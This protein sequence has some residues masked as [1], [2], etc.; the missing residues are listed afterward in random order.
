MIDEE[1]IE[2]FGGNEGGLRVLIVDQQLRVI[3]T[4][5][6]YRGDFRKRIIAV[7]QQLSRAID[8][9]G[10]AN[11]PFPNMEF[12]IVVDDIAALPK[13]PRA[14]WAFTRSSVNKAHDSLFLIPD[15]HFY[16][17]PPEAEG[18]QTMQTKARKHDSRI[19]DKIERLVWRGV[20]W[21]NKDIRK[22]LLKATEGKPWADVVVRVL[23]SPRRVPYQMNRADPLHSQAINWKEKKSLLSMDEYCKYRF[24]VNTEGECIFYGILTASYVY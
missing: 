16:A 23:S 5:G 17:S 13:E 19:Q 1:T 6:L 11:E 21:T 24:A 20:E 2:L 15:Q 4:K 3:Q 10:W 9:A 12:T 7:L 18:F 8:A 22:P 14:L